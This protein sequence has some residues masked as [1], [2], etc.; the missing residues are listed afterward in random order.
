MGNFQDTCHRAAKYNPV[1]RHWLLAALVLGSSIRV[2]DAQEQFSKLNVVALDTHGQPVT[3]LTRDDFQVLDDGKPQPIVFFRFTGAKS[4]Q[5]ALAPREYSN[6]SA[7]L[8]PPVAILFDMLNDRVL[9]DAVTRKEIVDALQNLEFSGNLYLYILTPRGE[10]FPVHPLPAPDTVLTP[11]TEP[12]TRQIAPILD[13]ALK[14]FVG[15]HQVDELD[16]KNRYEESIAALND[17]GGRMTEATGPKYLVWI[18]HGFPIFG[19]SMSVRARVDF[20]DPL[21]NFYERLA[22]SQILLY[23]IDQSM[24]GAGADPLTYSTETLQEAA[25]LTGGRRLT[26]DRVND[27]IAQAMTDARANY[28]IAFQLPEQKP[29][30]KRHK[31]RVTTS[32]KDIRLQ[33]VQAYYVLPPLP[34]ANLE[35]NAIDRTIHSP[36]EATDIGVRASILPAA[37]AKSFTLNIWVDAADLLLLKSGDNRTGH[38]ELLI[39]GYDANGFQ[40]ASKPVPFDLNLTP[41]QFESRLAHGGLAI[42][43]PFAINDSVQRIRVIAYDPGLN[44]TG[45]VT[46]PVKP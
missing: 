28:E 19:Y 1:M 7:P 14:P 2:A 4:A 26:S 41:A 8:R 40:Q 42:H 45:S 32:R 12:W 29:D 34:P 21:R 9:G 35:R 24:R 27:G 31:L 20:T 13:Q 39:A 38:I 17:L 43:Q 23:P 5:T 3:G 44:A 46:V 22:M 18:T 25:D 11:E 37:D 16:I 10:L 6:R 33:T 36:F 15:F 30:K